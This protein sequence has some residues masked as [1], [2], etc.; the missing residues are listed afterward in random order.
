SYN[1]NKYNLYAGCSM[2]VFIFSI[3]L[4]LFYYYTNEILGLK[5][6]III[7]IINFILI[8]VLVKK[9]EKFIQGLQGEKMVFYELLELVKDG[10]DLY[11]SFPCDK[12]DIDFI[13]VST[14]GLFV[15]EV[16]NPLK[17]SKDDKIVFSENK[18]RILYNDGKSSVLNNRDPI[19]QVKNNAECFSFYLKNLIGKSIDVKSVILF[20]GFLVEEY[21]KNDLI[22][23]NPKRFVVFVKSLPDSLSKSEINEINVAIKSRLKHI[24][25]EIWKE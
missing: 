9:Y 2:F 10:Y 4:I 19:K 18:L 20:P 24:H 14:K 6:S 1:L 16:K 5:I 22:V 23:L 8:L 13:L 17:K 12:F 7:F 11:P 21:I 15:I 25:D 3:F